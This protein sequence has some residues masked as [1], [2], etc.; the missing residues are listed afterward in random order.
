MN[1]TPVPFIPPQNMPTAPIGSIPHQH[2]EQN[3]PNRVAIQ[4]FRKARHSLDQHNLKQVIIEATTSA[5]MTQ[6]TI[7]AK[8]T[9]I[10]TR[11]AGAVSSFECDMTTA[12]SLL[13]GHPT[14]AADIEAFKK[15]ASEVQAAADNNDAMIREVKRDF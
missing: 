8:K 11:K 12:E 2:D 9:V 14:T 1:P 10:R 15:I 5:G 13:D 4:E 3:N 6:V 7:S